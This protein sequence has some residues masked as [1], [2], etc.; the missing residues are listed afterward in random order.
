MENKELKQEATVSEASR[1]TFG[2]QIQNKNLNG[3]KIICIGLPNTGTFNWQ[4]VPCILSL[5]IP[6]GYCL[7]FNVMANCLVYDARER[8]AEYAVNIGATHLLFL[9]SDMVPP[10]HTIISLHEKNVDIIS[11][12]IFQRKYPYQPCF[13]TKA[14]LT[15]DYQ[16]IMEGPLEPDKWPEVGAHGMEG[17]GMACTMIKT[18]I[19]KDIPKPWFFPAPAVG[20]DLAF[21]IKARKAGFKI[22]TDFG[23][24]CGHI[25][26]Y[27]CT[28][29][30]FKIASKAWLEDPKNKGKLIF[31]EEFDNV[32]N[33]N[34]DHRGHAG[35]K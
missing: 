15:K 4:F 30:S 2:N 11:G 29:E 35:Q 8:L 1:I 33:Q 10:S 16:P 14:R 17:V 23:V 27:V 3:K 13:Y 26:E 19:F 32:L 34:K 31:G 24:D 18:S 20:E 6:K 12:K 5:Q 21:C 7:N 25:G 9:D 28:T 22:Y